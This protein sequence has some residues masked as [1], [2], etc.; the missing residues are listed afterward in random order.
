MIACRKLIVAAATLVLGLSACA[1]TPTAPTPTGTGTAAVVPTA[2]TAQPARQKADSPFPGYYARKAR[3]GQT[4]Y[5]REDSVAGT[6][7]PKLV[8][9]TADT[10][11]NHPPSRSS[12]STTSDRRRARA[13]AILLRAAELG[14]IPAQLRGAPSGDTAG[15]LLTNRSLSRRTAFA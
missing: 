5:C 10:L 1:G 4:L 7:I 12:R 9:A 14:G 8:C 6:R 2:V 11:R 3:N 13:A 15:P